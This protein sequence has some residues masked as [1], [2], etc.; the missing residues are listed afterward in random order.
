LPE[1]TG[2]RR[3]IGAQ[4][5]AMSEKPKKIPATEKK[6]D[7]A[8]TPTVSVKAPEPAASP[9]AKEAAPI[10]IGPKSAAVTVGKPADG[11]RKTH[12]DEAIEIALEAASTAVDSAQ[13]IQRLRAETFKLVEGT[14]RNNKLVLYA[15]ILIFGISSVGVF[16]SLVYF[17][18]A[19]NDMEMLTTVNRDALLVFAG[20]IN[21]LVATAKKMEEAGKV[22]AT[23]LDATS[24]AQAETANALQALSRATANV[25]LSL[26][27]LSAQDKTLAAIKQSIDELNS[28]SKANT[29]RLNELRAATAAKPVVVPTS[30]PAPAPTPQVAPGR[31]VPPA[32]ARPGANANANASNRARPP[33]QLSSAASRA[34][35][36]M[37]RDS[38]IRYP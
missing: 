4:E 3:R 16:G 21:G 29:A 26:T 24:K 37:P 17:R 10:K 1:T 28:A 35:A 19:M 23:A 32:A 15:S 27:Q 2:K 20:E 5:F 38:M 14:R 34:V 36:N 6:T 31:S 13:E 33:R 7:K 25:N 8:E 22:G 18:R 30:A 12:I 11:P 9:E